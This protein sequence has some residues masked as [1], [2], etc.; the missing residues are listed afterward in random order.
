[1]AKAKFA[2]RGARGTALFLKEGSSGPAVAKLQAKLK[3]VGF[4]PG[5]PDG[6]F[7]PATTAALIGF[8]KSAGLLADGIA[9]TAHVDCIEFG[10]Q[11]PVTLGD[12][13]RDR[14]HRVEDVSVHPG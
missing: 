12:P 5:R 3:E 2:S 6:D 9:G 14:Q 8:Q 11:R 13:G 4:N 10:R 7:G 1:M